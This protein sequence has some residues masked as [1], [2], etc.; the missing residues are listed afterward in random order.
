MDYF[1]TIMFAFAVIM[2]IMFL[3]DLIVM[4]IMGELKPLPNK[5]KKNE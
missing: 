4:K 2:L 1:S 5:E 3:S